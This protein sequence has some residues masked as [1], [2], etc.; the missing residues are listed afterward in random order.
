[1]SLSVLRIA[2]PFIAVA[3]AVTLVWAL[4]S[5]GNGYKDQRDEARVELTA[6]QAELSLLRT[7]AA[8]KEVAAGERSAD[9]KL[10]E[11][12]EKELIDAIKEVPDEAPDAV[13]VHLGCQRLRA[14]GHID[15]DLPSV[16]R[17]GSG[18]EARTQP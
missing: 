3:L 18:A 15:T 6:A 9:E 1:M 16:C 10:I 17:L 7:D 8:L 2:G 12:A 14:A 4:W 5:R 11:Q 13:R